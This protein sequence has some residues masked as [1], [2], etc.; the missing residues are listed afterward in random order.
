MPKPYK[1]I[2]ASVRLRQ[3]A[4]S[5]WEPV[6]LALREFAAEAALEMV[7]CPPESLLRVQGMAQMAQEIATQFMNAPQNYDRMRTAKK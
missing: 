7:A 1:L 6:A 3:E 2:E 4:P 5:T